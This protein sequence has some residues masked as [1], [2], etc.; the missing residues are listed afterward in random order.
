VSL[1]AVIDH[2]STLLSTSLGGAAGVSDRQPLALA[3]LPHVAVSV[4]DA[5]RPQIGIGGMP[6]GP[7]H[8]ALEVSATIDLADPSL[9]SGGETIVLLDGSRRRLLLPNGPLVT[10]DGSEGPPF[11]SGDLTVTDPGGAYAVTNDPPTGRQVRPLPDDG[12]LEFGQALPNAGTLVVLHHVGVWD[13][14]VVRYAGRLHLDITTDDVGDAT[15]VARRV[16]EALDGAGP[17]Y[18]RLVATTWGAAETGDLADTPVGIRRLSYA[19]VFELHRPTLPTS[20]GVIRVVDVT[21]HAD[22]ATE[23]YQI[24]V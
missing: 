4:S 19:F 3:D 13:V 5:E 6:R 11:A 24:P 1:V 15:S 17:P 23:Q 9:E 18:E 20:G 8:G 7:V 22:S 16:A 14:T 10:A 21:S 12:V 2:T